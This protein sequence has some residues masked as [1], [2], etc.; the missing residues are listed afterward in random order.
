MPSLGGTALTAALALPVACAGAGNTG[1]FVHLF[2][3]SWP[4]V[5]AE[6]ENFLGP[7]GFKA[8]QVSPPT[9][10]I[11]GSQWWTR[12]Q[13]VSYAL[14]SRSGDRSG[15]ASM[16]SR[17]AA[18]G[19]DVYADAVTNHMAA[20][21]GTGVGGTAYGSRNFTLYA[22]DDFHH[23]DGDISKNCA[24]TNYADESNVQRCDL[25]GLPDLCTGC[26]TVKGP[27]GALFR[28]LEKLGVK[29]IRI[30]AAKH[31]DAGELGGVL[32]SS[33]G[34]YVFQEVIGAQGEAVQPD[35]YYTNGDVTEFSY[36]Y[37]LAPNIVNEGKMQYLSTFGESWGLMPS[38]SA[39]VFLDNHDTQRGAA[40]ITF[41]SGD[42]YT[43]ANVFMLAHSYGYPKVMSSYNFDSSDQGPPSSPANAD[44]CGGS[45]WVCEHRRAPIAN[46]VA[47][48]NSAGS[49]GVSGF[50]TFS[51]D[52]IAFGRGGKAWVAMNRGGSAWGASSNVTT[53]LPTGSYCNV[54]V[55]DNASECPAV[56]VG[57]DGTIAGLSVPS[58]GSVA[59]HVG[60]MKQ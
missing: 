50:A 11:Q 54:A 36:A 21:G 52:V 14:T 24:V 49:T 58:L 28:D 46:M 18:A 37:D 10:H 9:E 32:A 6:C 35:E 31:M 17:C 27:V 43:F 45:D 30:D 7:K 42:I 25:V 5:A 12:Y 4:D 13:P 53:G 3:W 57:G 55:S 2:E 56:V 8:V 26:A 16:V 38:S 41:K 48:R 44:T 1:A 39:V 34:M 51:P 23:D 22:P 33:A 20:G 47:W 29:G 15:F 19:V 60:A 40:P 59:L